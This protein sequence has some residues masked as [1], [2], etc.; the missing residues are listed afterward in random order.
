LVEFI[1]DPNDAKPRLEEILTK[2]SEF[3]S[4]TKILD[5]SLLLGKLKN[6]EEIR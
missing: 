4:L 1:R 5:Y 2:D 6:P 3:F